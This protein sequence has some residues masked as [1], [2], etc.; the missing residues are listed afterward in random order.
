MRTATNQP[1]VPVV[2]SDEVAISND[3]SSVFRVS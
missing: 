3:K 1:E 2:V